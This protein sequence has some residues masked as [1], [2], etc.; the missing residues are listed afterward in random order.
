MCSLR[1][2]RT[3]EVGRGIAGPLGRG[4]RGCRGWKRVIVLGAVWSLWP[5]KRRRVDGEI[6]C[7]REDLRFGI[8]E[9]R[10]GYKR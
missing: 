6:D 8:R 5:W 10:Y 3:L 7:V 4:G 9:D 1:C 2:K